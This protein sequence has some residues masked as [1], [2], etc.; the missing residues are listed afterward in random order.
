MGSGASKKTDQKQNGLDD[1]DDDDDF[2]NFIKKK[3]ENKGQPKLEQA[4]L[5]PK[6]GKTSNSKKPPGPRTIIDLIDSDDEDEIAANPRKVQGKIYRVSH[7]IKRDFK[8]LMSINYKP[9]NSQIG[10]TPTQF[11]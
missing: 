6:L 5:L 10:Q 1:N 8:S 3:A 2:D 7:F 11:M 4:G 9:G